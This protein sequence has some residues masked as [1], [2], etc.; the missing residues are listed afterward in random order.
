MIWGE[1]LRRKERAGVF[2]R[3]DFIEQRMVLSAMRPRLTRE[4]MSHHE[5]ASDVSL[6]H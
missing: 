1:I 6:I 3:S 2:A 4:M 5:L